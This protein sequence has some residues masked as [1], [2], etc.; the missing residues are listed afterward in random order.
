M[1]KFTDAIVELKTK[2]KAIAGRDDFAA[3]NSAFLTDPTRY[4][5]YSD[6]ALQA[7]WNI[8]STLEEATD[9]RK[10]Q[11]HLFDQQTYLTDWFNYLEA[12]QGKTPGGTLQIIDQKTYD[13]G[14]ALHA[15]L[16]MA[17]TNDE[18]HKLLTPQ[19]W[20]AKQAARALGFGDG[21]ENLKEINTRL[22]PR[23]AAYEMEELEFARY[24][25]NLEATLATFSEPPIPDLITLDADG[26]FSYTIKHSELADETERLQAD[27]ESY[28]SLISQLSSYK[29]ALSS[30]ETALGDQIKGFTTSY[31]VPAKVKQRE[32]FIEIQ[33]ETLRQLLQHYAEAQ[34]K[35]STIK[36]LLQKATNEQPKISA[37]PSALDVNAEKIK[38]L[39]VQIEEA[40]QQ[41]TAAKKS[42]DDETSALASIAETTT[43]LTAII[44]N[45]EVRKTQLGHLRHMI[46]GIKREM[47]AGVFIVSNILRA[48]EVDE[49]S[50]DIARVVKTQCHLANLKMKALATWKSTTLTGMFSSAFT[51]ETSDPEL[52]KIIAPLFEI[53]NEK[54][55][56]IAKELTINIT[57]DTPLENP[58][59]G[60]TNTIF[61]YHE[62]AIQTRQILKR[63]HE[64]LFKQLDAEEASLKL[65]LPSIELQL[66]ELKIKLDELKVSTL[67]SLLAALTQDDALEHINEFLTK[68]SEKINQLEHLQASYDALDEAFTALGAKKDAFT[69]LFGR[70]FPP[71]SRIP[72][73]NA[74]RKTALLAMGAA[75]E[76]Q[77]LAIDT[78]FSTF[79]TLA[80]QITMQRK[81]LMAE[82][83]RQIHTTLSEFSTQ[84]TTR[85]NNSISAIEALLLE[86]ETQLQLITANEAIITEITSSQ[87]T[88][89]SDAIISINASKASLTR[90]RDD[91]ATDKKALEIQEEALGKRKALKLKFFG[92][93]D[94]KI[95]GTFDKYLNE[96]NKTYKLRDWIESI[97]FGCF[98]YK[99]QKQRRTAY[100][101]QLAADVTAYEKDPTKC[102]KLKADIARAHG[103][104]APRARQGKGYEKS[105]K[106]HL[107]SLE[108]EIN[109]IE[110]PSA[111]V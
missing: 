10:G 36:A 12:P 103:L 83:V 44:E 101:E 24:K 99:T 109:K 25:A 54:E 50:S 86:I 91:L 9:P 5:S 96:R 98:G 21:I 58:L 104:F 4:P 32:R 77:K 34:K 39:Q 100:I 63:V 13:L 65:K 41:A 55:R 89:M 48:I 95:E 87:D 78:Q 53:L 97:I 106:A 52:E 85:E 42:Y 68:D 110:N 6:N 3:P 76:A 17:V 94:H 1:S 14:K 19:G 82:K 49:D 79:K 20:L 107:E 62:A 70:A 22:A 80:H 26:N 66:V 92:T 69:E 23:L 72:S 16:S 84:L 31:P 46:Q 59:P 43:A 33:E 61:A 38:V 64:L 27:Y 40:R 2:I 18:A 15:F 81:T 93:N 102:G 8:V 108:A 88:T 90:L 60:R 29:E 71:G 28:A 105:F 75:L 56:Q 74:E 45:V 35:H 67:E 30:R 7:I 111:S 47:Q 73:A 11:T 37:P 57:S 51:S